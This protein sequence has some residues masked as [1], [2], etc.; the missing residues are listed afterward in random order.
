VHGLAVGQHVELYPTIP[1]SFGGS[2]PSGTRGIVQEIDPGRAE[3]RIYRVRFLSSEMLTD[4]EAWLADT[5]I[6]AA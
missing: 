2:V 4:E 5:D 1:S 6:F 3:G